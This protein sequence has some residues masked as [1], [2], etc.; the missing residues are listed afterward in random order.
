VLTGHGSKEVLTGGRGRDLLIGGTA[1]ATLH[2][3]TQD[4]ILIG[5]WTNYDISSTGLTYAQKL[6]ALYAIMAEWGS[7]DPYNTRLG[8]L[9]GSLSTNNPTT[10]HDNYQTGVA[11]ADQLVG[12]LQASDWFFAELNDK[13]TGKNKKDVL[14][15]IQ[16]ET[17]GRGG[18]CWKRGPPRRKHSDR[19]PWRSG[20]FT[21]SCGR[22]ATRSISARGRAPNSGCT[23]RSPRPPHVSRE[24]QRASARHT[25]ESYV[26][27]CDRSAHWSW[28]F[29]NGRLA[30]AAS[31]W[32]A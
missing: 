20:Q 32:P 3:G 5:G 9:A 29:R 1:A 4:D 16:L 31:A 6:A 15:K 25:E 11:V 18:A 17:A 30:G 28:H 26:C 12:N 24:R 2:A 27:R 23:L 10:V 8:A 7:S 21:L 19:A 22:Q 14:T 13:V